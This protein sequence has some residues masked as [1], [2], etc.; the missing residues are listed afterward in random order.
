M[1]VL[2]VF[3]HP[4]GAEAH[5][6]VPHNRSLAAA[7]LDAVRGGL[8]AA[9]H[10]VDIADLAAEGFDPVM[11][12]AELRAWRTGGPMRED[13][14]AL[15]RRLSAADHLVFVFPVWWM[16]MP[17]GT[18][19]FLDRV[20]AKGF[21]FDEPRIGGALRSRLPRLRGVSVVSVMTTDD[22][23]YRWWFGRPAAAILGRGTF[24]LIGIRRFRHIS[25]G[26][27]TQRGAASRARALAG[28]RRR[29]AAL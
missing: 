10:S 9:G 15:Q 13:A 8:A 18:K 26:R 24:R 27:S 1:H 23:L 19:G 3:D 6:N 17:A 4:Y 20:L 25:I 5:E 16:A 12:A 7:A 29:F 2:V 22:T 28:V 21:A 11:S 14:G